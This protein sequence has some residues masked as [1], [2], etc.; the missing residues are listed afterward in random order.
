MSITRRQAGLAGAGLLAGA[1][2]LSRPALAQSGYP[3]RNI[4]IIAPVAPGSQTDV[5]FGSFSKALDQGDDIGGGPIMLVVVS[6]VSILAAGVLWLDN[7]V[8]GQGRGGVVQTHCGEDC[9]HVVVMT[10][11]CVQFA[12]QGE[13]GVGRVE[14]A[15]GGGVVVDGLGR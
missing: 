5:F 1:T 12:A 8:V 15:V 3:S 14:G 6:L 9:C 4:T 7:S 2:T 13:S 10:E 11:V